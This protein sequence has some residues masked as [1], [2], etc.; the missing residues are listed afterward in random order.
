M[1]KKNRVTSSGKN[2]EEKDNLSPSPFASIVLKEKKE[3]KK[4]KKISLGTKKPGEI[5]HGYNPSLSFA[6]ILSSY[7]KTGNP[8]SLPKKSQSSSKSFGDILDEWENGSSKKP[9]TKEI[10]SERGLS[11]YKATRSF[12]SI[13]NEYEGIYREKEEEKKK[14]VKGKDKAECDNML[15][16]ASLYENE[17][18]T[19]PSDV[20]WSVNGGK[21]PSFKREDVSKKKEEKV[22]KRSSSEYK[23]SSSF[24]DILSAYE[25]SKRRKNEEEKTVIIEPSSEVEKKEIVKETSFFIEDDDT[26]VPSNVSW[27]VLGGKNV[28]FVR[29]DVEE[30]KEK[31]EEEVEEKAE[32]KKRKEKKKNTY[33][34][35]VSFGDILSSYDRKKKESSVEIIEEKIDTTKEEVVEDEERFFIEKGKDEVPSNVS[36]SIIG[37]AN[38]NFTRP[39]EEEK[40]EEK[41]EKKEIKATKYTPTTSFSSILS[42]Y[43][44]KSE[45]REKTFSEIMEEKGDGRKKKAAISIN[46]LRRMDPQATLDLHGESQSD[47]EV[48]ISSFISECV[49]HGLRKISIITGKGLHSE[50]GTGVLKDLA[51]SLLSSS[52]YVKETSPAPLSKGGAGA[53]WVILKEK[54]EID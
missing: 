10:K 27:S 30:K 18:E 43:E 14:R 41:E 23:P 25:N 19:V 7:E 50:N 42:T 4:E 32:R 54:K 21:N 45:V 15:R 13:L 40:V 2:K 1:S 20:S 12:A 49:E 47:S 37:G 31:R 3:E 28:N 11:S 17:D 29:E 34:P 44:K 39:V 51:L 48:M 53:V 38:K 26:P 52:D 6:D 35:S 33:K 46:D 8:Y 24:S 9:K 36:W 5:V 16:T 22:Y